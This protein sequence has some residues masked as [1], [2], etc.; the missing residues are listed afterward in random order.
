MKWVSP[1]FLIDDREWESPLVMWRVSG[2]FVD[3]P[4]CYSRTDAWAQWFY[5]NCIEI[6]CKLR[7]K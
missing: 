7:L 4:M 5:H 3:G 6:L 1:V 2:G